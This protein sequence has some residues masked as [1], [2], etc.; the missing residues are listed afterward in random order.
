MKTKITILLL[1]I[2]ICSFSQH[3][4]YKNGKVLD[5]DGQKISNAEVKKI[6]SSQPEL[7]AKYNTGKTKS[8]AGGLL[9]GFGL[10]LTAADLVGGL[11]Q[12][13]KYPTALTYVG[14][15]ATLISIPVLSGR[16]K[17]IESAIDGYNNSS[18]KKVGFSIDKMNLIT[19]KNG[20]GMQLSF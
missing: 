16:T 20:I 9:L 2:S 11:T 3:L 13:V 19:N 8:T 6:L 1:L 17:K 12:D 5:S 15:A 4:S 10:G 7:L 14:L 18:P